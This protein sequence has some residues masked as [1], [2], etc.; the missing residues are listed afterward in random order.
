MKRIQI[1]SLLLWM[2]VIFPSYGQGDSYVQNL[3]NRWHPSTPYLYNPYKTDQPSLIMPYDSLNYSS[4]GL[5]KLPFFIVKSIEIS[6]DW[7][8]ISFDGKLHG[9]SYTMPFVAPMDWYFEKQIKLNREVAF[10]KAIR[11][12]SKARGS[13]SQ[14]LQDR[15]GKGIEVIG[16]DMGNIGR[17]SLTARGN[18]TIKGNLVFQDQEL[19]RSKLSETQNTHL[20][21]DQTQRISVEGK[22]GDRVSVNV[23]HDSERDFDWENNIRISY[24]GEEDD[25]VQTVDA[26]NVSLNLPGSQSLMGSAN[27]Q[28]LFGIKTV[29]KLGPMNI[30]AIASVVNTE[31]KSLE[32][33]GKSEAQTVK[34]QDYYYVKNKYFFIHEW[35][36]N[37]TRTQ[38]GAASVMVPPFYPLKEGLHQIGNVVVRNFELYQLDQTTNSETNPG[39]AFADLENPNESHDQTGNFKRLE[40]GQDYILSEDLGFIRL[41]QKASDE[42]LGCTFIIA[43]RATGDT[44]KTIGK[45]ISIDSEQLMM[46][47]LKPRDLNPSHPVWPLMFKNVYYLGTNNINR[48]GFELRI[49]NDRLPVPSHLDPQG[50][51]YITQFGLD[52]L[53]ESGV[54]TS[55]QKVDLANPNIISLAEGELFLP[56]FHP[57]AADTFPDGNKSAALKGSLGEGKMYFT[58]LRNDWARD[59][60]FTIEVDYANQSATINLGFMIVEGSE[61]VYKGGV[62]LKKGVDYQVD[63]FSGMI[64]LSDDADPNAEIKVNYDRHQL[65]TFDKKTIL[66]VRSQMDFGKNSFIGGTALYYNQSVMNEKVEVGYEPMRNF[67]WGLNGRYQQELPGLT[68]TLDRLPMIETEK[69]SAFSFE[70]EF[71]QIL[72]NPNPINNGATGDPNGV[73]FIDDF[74]GS[75]RTTSIPI[76]RR[77]WKESSAPLDLRT[78]KP[79]AQ[80]NRGRMNWFNPFVQ[81]RTKDIWPNLST[82]IQAQN[83]TTDIMVLRFDP[84]EHQ[85]DVL[86]D[87]IWGGIITPFYSGDYDQT[88]TKFFEIWLRGEEGAITVDLGQISEDMDGNGLLNTEDIPV[89]G[90]IGD[91]ILEDK[92]DIGLDG[93]IDAFENGWGSCLDPEGPSYAD[94]VASSEKVLINTFS[95]VDPEDPNGDKWEYSEGSNDYSKINGTEE[96]ALDA[97]RYPDTEDLDRTGFLDRTNNYFTKSFS[98]LDTTYFAGET[99]RNGEPTGWRLFRVPLAEFDQSNPTQQR[100]WNNIHHL[101]LT[102][103][104]VEKMSLVEVA[105]VE[106]VGNEWQELGVAP[107]ST[108]KYSKENADSVFAVSVINT[109]DNADYRPPQGVLGEYD[110]INQI[111]SKE[112]SLVL[113]F[114]KLPGRAS[115]AAMK[116]LLSLSGEKAQSY[117]SYDE[118]KMYVYGSGQW[119]SNEKSDVDMFMRFGFGENYYELVQPVYDGWDEG[120]NRNAVQ[121]DLEWLTR[122]KLQDSSSVKKYRETDIFMDST[123]YKEYRFTDE[124]GVETGKVIRIKGQPA[125]NRIQYFVVGVHN[126]I[127]TPI[128]GEVWLDELRLSGVN[129]DKGVSLRVQ[130]RFNLAD[131][132]N[133][134]FAYKRQ[135]AD[136][137]TLQRRLGSNKSSESFNINSSLNVDKFLPSTWGMKIPISTTFA[138]SV[139]RPKY[140]PGQDVLVTEGSEPDSILAKSNS[141]SFTIAASKS[142]KSDNKIMKYTIDRLNT[143]FSASR[144]TMSNEIQKEVLNETYV[145][146]LNYSLPF[147]RNNY[148]MPFKWISSVPWIGEKLG[149][150]HFYFTP[151]NVNASL[152]FNEKLTQK[153]P[154]RG[155][156][157][158]DSYNFGLNQSYSL[159]YKM[160]ESVKSKYSRAI[161]S[162]LNDHRGFMANAVKNRDAGVVT[163]ITESFNSSFSPILMDWLKPTF[164]YS[165][166]YRWNK[167]RDSSV[168]G[169]N[170]G[171]QLRFSSGISLSPVKLVELV[172]K[173]S[174]AKGRTPQRRRTPTPTRSR[175]RKS[176]IRG[177]ESEDD[178]GG[179]RVELDQAGQNEEKEPQKKKSSDSKVMKKVHGWARKVNPINLSYTENVNKTGMGVIGEVPL[180]YRIGY[181]RD[182]GLEN[183]TQ[184]G[185]NTGNWDH[186]RD[187]S[188]RSGL[189]LTRA[190]S[191]SFNYAQNVSSNRRGSGLEQRSMSRD[192]LSYGKHLEEGFPFIG[193]SIRM[194]GLERNKFIGR[195]V[196]TLSLDHATNGKETRAWQFDQFSGPSMPFFGIDDFVTS[197]KDNER[198]S[199]VNMNFAPLIG[200]TIALKKGI[201]VTMR[202]NR[203]LSREESAN[204]GEKIF[205]DQSYLISA[206][207]T[208]RGG[209]TIPFPFFDNYKVNNQV[210]FTFNF[211]MNKNRTLQKAQEATKF[212]ETAFTSSWKTGIRLTYSFSQSV[213]GSMIWEYRENDSKHT[214]KKIDRDFG[215]D[216]NLAI[217][218]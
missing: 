178:I 218:G 76:L 198:T 169:A 181:T 139:S 45:G 120:K 183:S 91:G 109:D 57:F 95:D 113:K 70:G 90:L 78:G 162:N 177:E 187:F 64:V 133:T 160:T 186:K 168:D 51:P 207:Y 24:K 212:A 104:G 52:S 29:S 209:F 25:I 67:I 129:K 7:S 27:H 105:K 38:V 147:G 2:T 184:V 114:N 189:N 16:V 112:Q 185:T 148:V 176:G 1:V 89:G 194:T 174:G 211:D 201:A 4:R 31:K 81:V 118:M 121:L 14:I 92:E 213:S 164:N 138:N 130:S 3:P 88:Q 96:N 18:V 191:I 108:E 123:D 203:T 149:K 34:I 49:I 77:F 210:N 128:S 68:R 50:N 136:F 215:F 119:I 151:E 158:P 26:G 166:N 171:N 152:N 180:R 60:R 17:V 141:M 196:R 10:E 94:Y 48:E 150:T 5:I 82:S 106:L 156:K 66:G 22:I 159:D 117:L 79:F 170:I 167:A 75:K 59:S 200:A 83:E 137:H 12:T 37:G 32:Y 205:H 61:Q 110:R 192:Y 36:R 42:V 182:H 146:Q 217:R 199:R 85:A 65:V 188:V 11:D 140:F 63:Y 100:E 204:G 53:N 6:K 47:M 39:T 195:F 98:L 9:N 131:I 69:Q 15:R 33:K 124:L 163:D 126:L 97:G 23:D 30:T 80:R 193:W 62:P 55:D 216:V 84:R 21:F 28:G 71:A 165:A 20:E 13:Q 74:E 107:D 190:M 208:H 72:P 135:D 122:L 172:Y 144:R 125:L 197:Y 43:D 116:T 145:G 73:A 44:I 127:E 214:G 102:L 155:N 101:R 41:R 54:R 103:S 154:R 93:C 206:N 132:M 35:F 142:S 175:S 8:T 173:P 87:S 161:K 46:K 157:S 153:T 134:S 56:V 179:G 99:E 202:H 143:R 40:Q 86:K 111:R 115:G 58:T 19:I